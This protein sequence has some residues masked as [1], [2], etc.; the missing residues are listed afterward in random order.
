MRVTGNIRVT[1]TEHVTAPV[2]NKRNMCLKTCSVVTVGD[3][4]WRAVLNE[5]GQLVRRGFTPPKVTP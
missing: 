4:L 5:V 2:R 1:L 3:V